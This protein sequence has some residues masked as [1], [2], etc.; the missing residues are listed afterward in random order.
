MVP[1]TDLMKLKAGSS[2]QRLE[3]AWRP[4]D[5]WRG[6]RAYRVSTPISLRKRKEIPVARQL[7]SRPFN[8]FLY[9]SFRIIDIFIQYF[10]NYGETKVNK[11]CTKISS[12]QE[13]SYMF[14][15]EINKKMNYQKE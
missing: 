5:A 8:I 12:C 6:A 2:V 9:T 1:F 10:L 14:N 4:S 11:L 13:C 3:C 7:K 15:L